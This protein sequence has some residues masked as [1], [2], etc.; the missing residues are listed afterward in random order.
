MFKQ[1]NSRLAGQNLQ[2]ALIDDLGVSEEEHDLPAFQTGSLQ[3]FLHVILPLIS[4]VSA[5]T[6]C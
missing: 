2:E 1:S 3:Q 5:E 4:S 6:K